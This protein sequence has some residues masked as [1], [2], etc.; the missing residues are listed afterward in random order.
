MKIGEI[1]V[2]KSNRIIQIRRGW[3]GQGWGFKDPDAYKA[4]KTAPCY[5]S[6]LEEETAYTGNDFLEL[7]NGQKEIAD[8]V[9]DMVDWQAPETLIDEWLGE[10]ELVECEECGKWVLAMH[11]MQESDKVYCPTC[12]EEQRKET[13]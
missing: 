6:E 1:T 7:C 13:I 8:V 9:F 10:G 11:M 2:D 3:L 12:W 5:V 4:D